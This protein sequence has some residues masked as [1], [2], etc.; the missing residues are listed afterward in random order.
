MQPRRW[1]GRAR[2]APGGVGGALVRAGLVLAGLVFAAPAAAQTRVHLWHAY[3]DAEEDA[4]R[5]VARAFERENPG[6]RVELLAN[7]FG[8]YASKLESAI[9]TGR[10]PDVFIDA[11]ERLASYLERRL[12]VPLEG[13][14]T[15]DLEPAHLDALRSGGALY[16][17][18]L[19]AKCAALYLNDALFPL[20]P[21]EGPATLEDVLD[22]PRPPRGSNLVFEAENAYYAA[23]FVHAFGGRMLD[24]EGHYAFVGAEAERALAFLAEQVR[25]GA[26]PEE[27]SGELVRRSFR[28]GTAIAA[29]S[30]P[31]LA[32]DL[33]D[34]LPWR[35][36]PLPT[37]RA[38]G[39]PLRPYAT[40]E[41]AFVAAN[42]R[43]EGAARRLAAFLASPEAARVRALRGRQVV[44]SRAAW[45]DP[46]LAG[47]AFLATFRDASREAVPMP[48]HPNMR[49]VFEPA[50]R[51]LRRVLRGGAPIEDSLEGGARAFDDLT[52][53]MPAP[54]DPTFGLLFFGLLLLAVVF[55]W[56]KAL[57]DPNQR[58]ALRASIPA[59]KYL[60][61]AFLAVGLL[62]ILPLVV[63]GLTSLFAGRGTDL[64]YVGLANYADILSARG[65][66]LLAPGSFWVVLL[67][68]ILWT[69]SNLLLHVA[70][71]V[72]LAVVLHRPTLKL[73]GLYRV[74]LILPWAVPSYVTALAWKGLFHRQL[75]A[76]NAILESLGAEPVSW[77]AH[78]STAFAANLSTNVWL[79]FPFMMVVTLGA[80]SSIPREL[81][82]AADV[83]GATR[84]QRFRYITLPMLRPALAPAVAMGAVWTFNMFNVVFLVSGGEP[85]GTTEILV[86]EAYRWAFTRGSQYGYAAAYAVLIFGILVVA[87][88]LFGRKL[89][90]ASS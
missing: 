79:G 70:I 14:D 15:S 17:L 60:W 31:W 58:A 38:S 50:Q 49:V 30:G 41:A 26:I 37:L 11:H 27:A 18:P 61:H 72:S 86:S 88:R 74:L 19:S 33:P 67:V 46:A 13:A 29:I 5:E 73:K 75:G 65:G 9:P 25:R 21:G 89:T 1:R 56:V 83:D 16:G 64:H 57:R 3:G 10:G 8:A 22:A 47:D 85:D 87:T 53:P 59:Y 6:V 24:D 34:D 7:A 43:N 69:V 35:V 55:S 45:D 48:T 78:W 66:P 23:A 20:P 71:G 28:G 90:E 84:W 82:E 54:R 81:Y 12:V 42:A 51:A 62:V 77:F 36:V 2:L 39:A 68:T 76:I 4:I 32:P 52:R 44:S 40:V 80:L 63:G